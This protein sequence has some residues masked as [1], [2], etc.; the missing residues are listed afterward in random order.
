MK[1]VSWLTHA[2]IKDYFGH[3]FWLQEKSN[4]QWPQTNTIVS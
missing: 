4:V 2:T 1:N 3:F